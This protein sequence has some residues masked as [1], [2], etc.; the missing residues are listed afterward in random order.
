[1]K[2]DFP[3]ILPVAIDRIVQKFLRWYYLVRN[4]IVCCVWGVIY[5][6]GTRFTGRLI[7]R[8]RRKG[9]IEIGVQV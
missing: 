4:Y 9:S 7:V 5:G 8:T 1:M 2:Y 3:M 6:R